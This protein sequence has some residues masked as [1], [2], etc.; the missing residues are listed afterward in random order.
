[1][2]DSPIRDYGK[3]WNL[4]HPEVKDLFSGE[5]TVEEKVDGSQFSFMLQG[6]ALHFRSRSVPVYTGE[7]GMFAKAVSAVYDRAHLLKDGWIYRG[8]YLQKPKHN[9]LAY[10][11]VPRGNIILFDV[12]PTEH[13]HLP[14]DEKRA[15]AGRVDLECVPLVHV[16]PLADHSSLMS[17]MTTVSCLGGANVEGL[18][19]KNYGRHGMDGK[20]LKGKHVAE[21]F[22][23][24]KDSEWKKENPGRQ[25][26]LDLLVMKYRSEA[27]YQKAVNHLRERGALTSSPADIGPLMAEA[28]DDLD[29]EC[30]D[31]MRQMLYQWAKKRIGRQIVGG[32]PQWYKDQLA[33]AQFES[34]NT[35]PKEPK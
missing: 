9:V 10:D 29:T 34:P 17:L 1:M 8:E 22:K 23:E 20:C 5:V 30:G 4:G 6:A 12:Q 19:F 25:D 28:L 27:R 7:S 16:G 26:I 13:T 11:R 21:H 15:E 24:V 31:E 2:T 3:V 32:L 33:K 14:A 35:A 18:V